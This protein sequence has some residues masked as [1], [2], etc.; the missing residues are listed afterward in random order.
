MFSKKKEIVKKEIVNSNEINTN[1]EQYINPEIQNEE[2]NQEDSQLIIYND[3]NKN[4]SY[5]YYRKEIY[6]NDDNN[7]QTNA[8]NLKKKIY[9]RVKTDLFKPHTQKAHLSYCIYR[10][11]NS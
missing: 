5:R 11:G 3:G 9:K 8:T 6:I 10:E 4:T 1:R 2:I 7:N